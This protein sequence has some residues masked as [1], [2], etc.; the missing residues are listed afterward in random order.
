MNQ[1]LQAAAAL[2][3]LLMAAGPSSPA[4]QPAP[5][6]VLA[7]GDIAVC[8]R[9]G[10]MRTA[11]L[12]DRLA[13]TI[14]PV[15]DLAYGEGTKAQFE[16]CYGST[17]GR[18]KARTRPVPGN[19][20]YRS[21]G[22]RP[23][24]AYWGKRAGDGERGFYSFDA[25]AWHVV[26]L[27][28]NIGAAPGSAQHRW[29]RRDLEGSPARCVLAFWHHPLFSSG[30]HGD[31]PKM[32]AL[33]HVLY[34]FGASLVISGHGHDYER[35]AP[36]DAEGRL[37]MDRGLRAFVVGSGGAGLY[38]LR[39]IHPNSEA[40]QAEEWGILELRLS[41]DRYAWRFVAADGGSAR[42]QGAAPCN[43]RR[44]PG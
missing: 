34:D 14:F 39:R 8:G 22:A 30:R 26:A 15:G 4:A 35:F 38:K 19:H 44:A 12:L 13:G 7:A 9:P 11:A 18:H 41:A 27:N 16:R 33:Y 24:F 43:A 37:D 3:G 10:A 32:A 28:S 29:L 20:E 40:F 6:I 31:N 23:Y 36:Q 2:A 5:T 17:W 42:D 21:P 1:S 25:G